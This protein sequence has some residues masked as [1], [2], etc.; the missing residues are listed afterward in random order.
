[1]NANIVLSVKGRKVNF[2]PP[3]NP[4]KWE[5]ILPIERIEV[6]CENS[7]HFERVGIVPRTFQKRLCVTVI[8]DKWNLSS[9]DNVVVPVI[10]NTALIYQIRDTLFSNCNCI[11]TIPMQEI[12]QYI[13]W[14][15]R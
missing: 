15:R 14:L 6:K 9:C 1:M 10:D 8:C 7:H 11:I 3:E 4:F 12:D 13:K 5:I 2:N